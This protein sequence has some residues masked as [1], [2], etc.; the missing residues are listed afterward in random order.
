MLVNF[1]NKISNIGVHNE[2]SLSLNKKVVILNKTALLAL[3]IQNAHVVFNLFIGNYFL[4]FLNTAASST[5]Y[6]VW[7]FNYYRRYKLPVLIMLLILPLGLIPFS[8]LLGD[9]GS[10]NF[11][12]SLMVLAFYIYDRN[13]LRLASIVYISLIFIAIKIMLNQKLGYYMY[14]DLQPIFYYMNIFFSMV[15]FALVSGVY[16]EENQRHVDELHVLNK[17]LTEQNNFIN[18]LLKELNHRVKNNLQ[19]VSS[20]FN[21]QA[22]KTENVQLRNELRDARDRIIT[23][24]MVHRKLYT[25]NSELNVE[26]RGY[27]EDLCVY[28][29]QSCGI[30]DKSVMHY[31]IDNIE[32]AIEDAVH[33]GLIINE[34]VTNSMKYGLTKEEGSINIVLKKLQNNK[35]VLKIS[36]NGVGFPDGMKIDETISFGY[37]LI[38]AIVEQHDGELK[39]YNEKG[40]NIEIVLEMEVIP[41]V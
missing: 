33:M 22:N 37:F 40:A 32:L 19:M 36:D 14:P 35:V 17:S 1:F 28:L 4:A 15:S 8:V 11:L 25:G 29:L 27:V 6:F 38:D 13:K 12:F 3:V 41:V 7:V 9:V 24:A 10:D 5:I 18:N 30:N 2:N 23:I 20:L 31:Q 34:L 26:L 39:Y 16:T 21:L